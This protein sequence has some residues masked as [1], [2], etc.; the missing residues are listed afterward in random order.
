[1]KHSLEFIRFIAVIL[2][3][4]THTRH[5]FE[6]GVYY[7]LLEVIPKYG[8]VILSVVSG[9][10]YWSVSRKKENL[11]KK[12]VKSLLIP[13]LIANSFVILAVITAKILGYDFLNRLTYDYTLITEGLLSLNSPPVNPPTFFIRDIFVVFVIIELITSK[14][15]KMFLILV[16]LAIF[17]KLMLRYD[18]LI[19]FGIGILIGSAQTKK[20][21]YLILASALI[22]SLISVI[23]I[24]EYSKYFISV[25]IFIILL[26]IP[27]K[28]F[29]SGGYSYLLHLYHSPVIVVSFP[30]LSIFVSDELTNVTL[31]ILL[32]AAFAYLLYL[33]TRK[34]KLLKILTGGR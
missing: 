18:I 9:Y 3:T 31:Q 23:Y 15:Y 26:N 30:L 29:N 25:A 16:P 2:I 10:L 6:S 13:Y 27:I 5:N 20:Q 24:V 8:T 34:I 14:N 19:M 21:N 7:Y 33:I 4:F 28:F 11:F 12:K 1:M 22:L 17:G 32:S